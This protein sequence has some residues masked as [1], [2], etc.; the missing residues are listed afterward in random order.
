MN[1]NDLKIVAGASLLSTFLG[2]VG[3]AALSEY[4]HDNN[5]YGTL[6]LTP[7]PDRYISIPCD[8]NSE[9]GTFIMNPTTGLMEPLVC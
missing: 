5:L 4:R 1:R 7:F 2:A 9:N 3:G 6:R 8:P